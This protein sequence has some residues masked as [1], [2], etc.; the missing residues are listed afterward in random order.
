MNSNKS[1]ENIFKHTL[2]L[3]TKSL[4]ACPNSNKFDFSATQSLHELG[5]KAGFVDFL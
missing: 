3:T 2:I 5:V 1:D 4:T